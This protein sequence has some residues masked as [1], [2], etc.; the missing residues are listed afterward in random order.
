MYTVLK[1]L[2]QLASEEPWQ[3]LPGIVAKGANI[4]M[5]VQDL[6]EDSESY[7]RETYG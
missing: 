3:R 1:R 2:G 4:F 6:Y 7:K 5:A